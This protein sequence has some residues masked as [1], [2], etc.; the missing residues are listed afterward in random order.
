MLFAWQ[1][2]ML[3]RH[4]LEYAFAS[5]HH[6]YCTG[7]CGLVCSIHAFPQRGAAP[8]GCGT[9]RLRVPD[10]NSIRVEALKTSTKSGLAGASFQ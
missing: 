1:A 5:M 8:A 3:C 4:A 2:A 10:S 9:N 6:W 7:R